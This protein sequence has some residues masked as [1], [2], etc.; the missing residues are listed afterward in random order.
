[1]SESQFACRHGTVGPCRACVEWSNGVE[2]VKTPCC[3]Y[4]VSI[5]QPHYPVAWNPF[6]RVVQCHNCGTT[7]EPAST[8]GK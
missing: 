2:R 3:N 7:Y 5:D 8:G 6:N 1:M 4:A